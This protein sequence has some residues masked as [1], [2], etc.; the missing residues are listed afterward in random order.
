MSEIKSVPNEASTIDDSV[1]AVIPTYGNRKD[2]L[3]K[4]LTELLTLKKITNIVIIDNGCTWNT[5]KFIEAIDDERIKLMRF[6][7]NEGSAVAYHHGIK[8]AST[9]DSTYIW[10]LDDDNIPQ[11]D[12]L[13]NLLNSLKS[14]TNQ[15][16]CAN[17]ERM[18]K[19]LIESGTKDFFDNHKNAF[20][21]FHMKD[22]PR[23]LKKIACQKKPT[24]ANN[25][26]SPISV[27]IAPYGG[28]LIP[29]SLINKIGFPL[30]KMVLYA[31]DSEYTWRIS[32]LG[33]SIIIVC[34]AIIKDIDD[35]HQREDNH[36]SITHWL[37]Q[38][39]FKSYYTVRNLAWL[40]FYKVSDKKL[41]FTINII[42][43]ILFVF[44]YAASNSKIY[45]FLTILTAIKD[46]LLT[47]LGKN[48][49][50]PLP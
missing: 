40:E 8:M 30:N 38:K 50:F 42:L 5:N 17:R 31:D 18:I 35:W 3:T 29:R 33:I 45:E 12:C 25:K 9:L 47:N 13:H 2:Y 28:L 11:R 14:K 23:K 10:L 21:G 19:S 34:D 27:I 22:L 43:Y 39:K 6:E 26:C 32:N 36:I 49:R 37:Y 44:I 16:A 48:D 15:V 46:G 7:E 41:V 4:L 1:T 20:L 24:A